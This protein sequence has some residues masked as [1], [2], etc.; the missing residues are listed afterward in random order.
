MI[1]RLVDKVIREIARLRS[2]WYV[3]YLRGKGCKI[4]T[5]T[6]FHGRK[7]VDITR[8][9][10]VEIGDNVTI[11]DDVIILTHA[12][13]WSVLR[14]AFHDPMI[15][16]SAGRVRIGNNVFIGTRAVITM[17]I[18]IGDNSIVAASS[19]VTRDVP[20][21]TL[22]AG[23][24]ARPI[25]SLREHHELRRERIRTECI[26]YASELLRHKKRV[27]EDDFPEFFPL[28]KSRATSL[29][30]KQLAQLGP[31]SEEFYRTTPIWQGLDELLEDARVRD[32]NSV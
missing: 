28:F 13:D 18:T 30:E 22:V 6:K 12:H 17:G 23:V 8:P 14:N 7:N 5:G 3:R 1:K 15:V 11:T 16:G 20:S 21:E 26:T 4:G 32:T 24:P 9:C 31:S 25:R 29:S 27:T 19:V 10:L 2:N